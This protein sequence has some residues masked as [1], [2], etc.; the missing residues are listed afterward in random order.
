MRRT[1]DVQTDRRLQ[2]L[3][4]TDKVAD[5]LPSDY[6]GVCTVF[7]QHTTAGV[8]VNEA[9][10]RLLGDIESMLAGTVPDEGWDHD[11]LD[12]NADSHLRA[13]LV[14]NG[15]SIPVADGTLDLGRWQSVLLVECDGPRTRTVTVATP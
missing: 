6:D 13:L 11:K 10:S 9:E 2:A 3:D 14:G 8:C 7:S 5:A 4:V 1:F 15:I 12:G